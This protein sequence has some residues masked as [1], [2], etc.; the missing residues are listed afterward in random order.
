[1]IHQINLLANTII[2]FFLCFLLAE[3]VYPHRESAVHPD[4]IHVYNVHYYRMIIPPDNPGPIMALDPGFYRMG[5]D[6][7]RR[8]IIGYFNPELKI[9]FALVA[10]SVV[11]RFYEIVKI[12]ID[13]SIANE[14]S[15]MS[16]NDR[17]FISEFEPGNVINVQVHGPTP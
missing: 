4:P 14:T 11:S 5:T 1:M 17:R 13:G 3:L 10:R 16:I 2:N 6:E 15:T 7:G 9:L 12:R 8:Y